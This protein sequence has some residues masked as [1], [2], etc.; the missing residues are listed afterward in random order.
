VFFR[1]EMIV[2]AIDSKTDEACFICAKTDH[3]VQVRI[4]QPKF[5]GSICVS[6]LYKRVPEKEVNDVDSQDS[7]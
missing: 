5:V 3:C 4:K 1:R 7:S 6:C 2:I